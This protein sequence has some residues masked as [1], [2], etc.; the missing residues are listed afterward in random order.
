MTIEAKQL[1]LLLNWMS[2]AFP[3]GSFSYSHG[4]EWA[5]EE[6]AVASAAELKDWIENLIVCGSGWNDAVIFAQ[7]WESDPHALNELALALANSRE[8]HLESTQLGRAFRLAAST[9]QRGEFPE[10]DDI[11]YPVATGMAC[12]AAGLDRLYGLLAYLQGFSNALI[13]VAVKL[14][15]LGHTQGLQVARDLMSI[16]ATIAD[17]AAAATLDDLGSMTLAA[18]IAAMKHETLETRIFRT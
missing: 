13:S 16:I 2:P 14:I 1:L 6:G 10:I 3:V 17:R 12:H 7:C 9:W 15:P 8:R 4:L 5:I 11:A 18:D